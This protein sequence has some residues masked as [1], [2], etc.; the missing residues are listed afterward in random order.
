M[1]MDLYQKRKGGR[2]PSFIYEKDMT[3]EVL[4]Q[5]P[6]GNGSSSWGILLVDTRW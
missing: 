4:G 3:L 2:D 5:K 6:S 1:F